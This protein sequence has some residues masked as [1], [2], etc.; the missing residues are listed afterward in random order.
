MI[1]LLST[2]HFEEST[3]EIV[4]WLKFFGGNY[5]RINGEDL[6]NTDFNIKFD[7]DNEFIQNNSLKNIKDVFED[8]RLVIFNRRWYNFTSQKLKLLDISTYNTDVSSILSYNNSEVSTIS[9]YFFYL[10]NRKN[11]IWIDHPSKSH[12]NK[13][14]VISKSLK[15]GL[16]VPET[17]ITSKAEDVKL[18]LKLGRVICKPINNIP[19]FYS[20][21]YDLSFDTKEI[22]EKDLDSIGHTFAHSLFQRL[23]EKMYEVRVFYFLGKFY[24]VAIFSQNREDSKIDYRNYSYDNP[25][26]SIPYNLPKDIVGKLQELI[27]FF[28]YKTCSIDLIVDL[29]GNYYF[30]EINPVGQF[31]MVSKPGNY[32]IER[33]IA[34]SLIKMDSNEKK[35]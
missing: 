29:K 20:E 2:A 31:G 1:V 28:Q 35:C 30:L 32:Y 17:I 15:I 25:D 12:I 3:N 34:L 22:K 18:F 19:D 11:S 6:L 23:I 14:I 8:K 4:S 9:G 27:D 16:N 33:E 24:S 7:K 26:R 5:L 10:L 13:L 21:N